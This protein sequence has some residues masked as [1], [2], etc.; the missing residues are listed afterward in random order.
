M[1]ETTTPRLLFIDFETTGLGK[2]DQG[3]ELAWENVDTGETGAF[4]PPH[5]LD[6]A[7]EQALEIQGYAER[8]AGQPHADLAT[9]EE[10]WDLCGGDGVTTT[11]MCANKTFDPNYLKDMFERAGLRPDPFSDPFTYRWFDIEDAAYWLFPDQFPYGS[12]PGLKDIARVLGVDN[13]QHH[14]AMNDV[15]VGAQCWRLLTAIRQT[16]CASEEFFRDRDEAIAMARA[17]RS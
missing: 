16:A 12:M 1:P 6:G 11:L 2:T 5:S 14:E 8:I 7:S 17:G 10:F 3:T 9:I 4:I 15:R 13:P